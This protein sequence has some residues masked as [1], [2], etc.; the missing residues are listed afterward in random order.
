MPQRKLHGWRSARST[1]STTSLCDSSPRQAPT[2]NAR[3]A[4]PNGIYLTFELGHDAN[5]TVK[6]RESDSPA[7]GHCPLSMTRTDGLIRDQWTSHPRRDD[8]VLGGGI[9]PHNRPV[10]TTVRAVTRSTAREQRVHTARPSVRALQYLLAGLY[11]VGAIYLCAVALHP[12]IQKNAPPWRHWFGAPGSMSTIGVI[13]LIPVVVLLLSKLAGRKMFSTTPLLVLA[14]MALSALVFGVSSYWNCHDGQSPLFAPV[15]WTV[16]LFVGAYEN[17]YDPSQSFACSKMPVPAALELARM[18]ALATTLTTAIA[19]A[20]KL[21]RSQFDRLALVR[22]RSLTVVVGLDEDSL[23]M[24][25]AIASRVGNRE[26][27]VVVTA[28]PD[29]RCIDEA[30]ALGARVRETP[31]LDADALR[32]LRL[33][34]HTERLYLISDDPV[35]NESRLRAIDDAMDRL[36]VDKPRLPLTVRVDDPWQAEVWRRH[37]LD[38]GAVHGTDRGHRRWVADAVGRYETTA[39]TVLRHVAGVTRGY[40]PPDTLLICGLF[41]L[42]YALTSELSQM[43]REQMVYP[44]PN[45]RLPSRM[46]VMATGASGFLRDHHLR[47][48]RIAPGESLLQIEPLN[49]DPTVDAISDFV[50]D[51]PHCCVVLT[52][53]SMETNGTRL[54]ARFPELTIYVASSS[55][56]TLPEASVVSRI[57]P[58]PISM[59]FDAGAPQDAWERAAELIHEAYRLNVHANGWPI[60]DDVDRDWRDLDPFWQQSNRRL[61]THTLALVESVGHTWNTL[62]HPPAAPLPDNFTTLGRSDKFHALGFDDDTT[63]D[64]MVRAEHEDWR[65][66]YEGNRWRFAN[67]RDDVKKR[68]DRLLPWDQLL[69]QDPRNEAR[70]QDTIIEALLILRSLGFRCIRKEPVPPSPVSDIQGT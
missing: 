57:F 17:R 53:P 60:A 69:E 33:W 38:A 59:N 37:F 63:L 32:D 18:L 9:L 35:L 4:L 25:N 40:P 49:V 1:A 27:L 64:L 13:L 48:D 24:L 10:A 39:A 65:K 11:A 41:P 15:S 28:A 43:H 19:A 54:A 47:Q 5:D 50:A 62:D 30:R 55:A 66:F 20:R 44:N 2:K 29:R 12:S 56:Q 31:T 21:F 51:N 61:V 6:I 46:L 70:C 23:S 52:D 36:A 8:G 3:C 67:Q 42:T 26:T 22:A 16:G 7:A 34:K 14:A 58:F 45:L 68:H